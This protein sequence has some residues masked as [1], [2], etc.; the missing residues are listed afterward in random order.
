MRWPRPISPKI[1]RQIESSVEKGLD[2]QRNAST[3]SWLCAWKTGWSKQITRKRQT[4]RCCLYRDPGAP[5]VACDEPPPPSSRT[6]V[7]PRGRP[8]LWRSTARANRR[9][10]GRDLWPQKPADVQ[11]LS[12][13]EKARP[14]GSLPNAQPVK[15]SALSLRLGN[16]SLGQNTKR[17]CTFE[18]TIPRI[19]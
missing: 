4:H 10:I 1:P 6:N 8:V 9:L 19:I 18:G 17:C 12:K 7:S 16:I 5:E 15:R 13:R 11:R 3:E 2:A 14:I